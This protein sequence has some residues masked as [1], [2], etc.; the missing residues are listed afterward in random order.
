M[1]IHYL[2]TNMSKLK[3]VS[4]SFNNRDFLVAIIPDIISNSNMRLLIGPHSMNTALFDD[5]IGY[6]SNE[7]RYI[8]EQIYA[9]I[10]D[11]YF[12]LSHEQF[13]EKVLLYLD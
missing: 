9:Y 12:S 7:A 8:D 1:Q 5:E 10:D 2:C 11:E 4:F 6:V 3:T 13:L